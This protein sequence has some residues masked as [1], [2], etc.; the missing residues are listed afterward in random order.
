M[1]KMKD[2]PFLNKAFMIMLSDNVASPLIYNRILNRVQDQEF[3]PRFM[4]AE[5][6]LRALTPDQLCELCE[7][8]QDELEFEVSEA[9]QSVLTELFNEIHV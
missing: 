2:T 3:D 9:T 5:I 8:A 6:E 4:V 7:G 1:M